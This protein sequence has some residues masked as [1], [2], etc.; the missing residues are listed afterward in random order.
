[1]LHRPHI[2]RIALK[3]TAQQFARARAISLPAPC[4]RC[5][6]ERARM[7]R[8]TFENFPAQA[9]RA[10]MVTRGQGCSGLA[11]PLFLHRRHE[12]PWFE[13]RESFG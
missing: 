9:F 5:H 7:T 1:L 2:V 11:E 6:M 10:G 8:S 4:Q 13:D 12:M 3:R